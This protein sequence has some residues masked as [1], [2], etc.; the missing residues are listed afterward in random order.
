MSAIEECVALDS[1]T[2][3]SFG[4]LSDDGTV[5]PHL[6]VYGNHWLTEIHVR[7]EAVVAQQQAELVFTL[8]AK[9]P[10]AL[11][12]GRKFLVPRLFA[13]VNLGMDFD[14]RKTPQP[15]HSKRLATQPH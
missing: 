14:H 1:L 5:R 2:T 13:G 6:H 7:F 10:A 8:R 11:M 12:A 4:L 9:T 3:C 15:E